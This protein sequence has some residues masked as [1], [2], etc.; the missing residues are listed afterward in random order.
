MKYRLGWALAASLFSVGIIGTASAADMAVKAPPLPV[1]E[2]WTWTG[3]YVGGNLGGAWSD[4]R[5]GYDMPFTTPGNIFTFC[6]SPAGVAA[7]VLV[8]ANPFDLST[9]CSRPSSFIGGAQIGYNWQMG[10]WVVG[11]EGDGAWQQLIQHSFV[12]FG[13]NR[14]V[15]APMGTVAS[16]TAYFRSEQGALGTVRGRIGYTGGN[17]LLYATGGLAVGAVKHSMTEVLAPGVACPVA[18]RQR[19]ARSATIQRAS[20]GLWVQA[21]NGC[22]RGTGRSAPNTS[23]STLA[24]RRSRWRRLVAF[25]SIRVPRDLTTASTWHG[26]RS[27]IILVDRW[28]PDTDTGLPD[29]LMQSPGLK[30]GLFYARRDLK[31]SPRSRHRRGSRCQ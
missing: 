6:G 28:S 18:P 21:P 11:I 30:P 3:F 17:W 12:Q 5:L 14:A 7:P 13:T 20:V 29:P 9:S 4:N 31:P 24:G 27:T 8:G 22:S 26:S 25:S 10:T 1:P 19:V 16:D 23:M 15:G 2:V